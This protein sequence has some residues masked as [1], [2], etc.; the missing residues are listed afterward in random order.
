MTVVWKSRSSRKQPRKNYALSGLKVGYGIVISDP[1]QSSPV[2][3]EQPL[4]RHVSAGL[5]KVYEA[6]PGG[7]AHPG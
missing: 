3:T 4:A 6:S 2:G 1:Q 7:T 5:A